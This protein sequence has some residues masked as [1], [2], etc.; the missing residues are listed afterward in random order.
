[1][2]KML[3]KLNLKIKIISCILALVL[4]VMT[5]SIIVVYFVIGQQNKTA[6]F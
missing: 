5:A 4:F 2:K 6:A 1:M 3:N